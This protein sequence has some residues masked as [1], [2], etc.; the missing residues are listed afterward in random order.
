[1]GATLEFPD[2]RGE[3]VGKQ[4]LLEIVKQGAINFCPALAEGKVIHTWSGLR[5]RPEGQPA[6]VIK[7]LAGHE[8]VILATGHYRNGVLLAPATAIA[9]SEILNE[10]YYL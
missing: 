1:V 10:K 6:P 8:Q 5:P 2:E 9:V 7:K 4:E 3:V